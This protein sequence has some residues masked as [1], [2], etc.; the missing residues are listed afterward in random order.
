MV[1]YNQNESKLSV[2]AAPF[3]PSGLLWGDPVNIC[4]YN[5]GEPTMT[6]V[7]E[8]D[9]RDIL[10]GID[11]EALDEAFPPDAE[12]AFELE[13]TEAFVQEMATL[14]MLEEREE[15]ARRTFRHYEKRWE[16]RRAAGPSGRPR[17]AMHLILPVIH[18]VKIHRPDTTT[19]AFHQMPGRRF[20]QH[21]ERSKLEKRVC[22]RRT[23]VAAPP[24]RPIVQP[25]K[26][27]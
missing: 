11:D 23:K 10:Q 2:D 20:V 12:E 15:Q 6:L 3:H 27:S 25:R 24:P 5:E 19:L 13:T 9:R 22:S 1:F 16:V 14:A 4:I 17:P 26:N 18:D 7:T 8:K 21:Y